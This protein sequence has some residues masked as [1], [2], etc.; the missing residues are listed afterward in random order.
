M[1][2]VPRLNP[3][4]LIALVALATGP[5]VPAQAQAPQ[6]AWLSGAVGLSQPLQSDLGEWFRVEA[7][8]LGDTLSTA[9]WIDHVPLT[10]MPR[11]EVGAPLGPEWSVAL[12]VE[13]YHNRTENQAFEVFSFHEW[14]THIETR[15]VEYALHGAWW[16]EQL[17]GGHVGASIGRAH[18]TV[19]LNGGG[20]LGTDPNQ[21]IF[22]DGTWKD[23]TFTWS[24][25][26]GW[27]SR[28][29][30]NPHVDLRV[31]WQGRNFGQMSARW[32]GWNGPETGPLRDAEG[33]PVGFDFGGPFASLGFAVAFRGAP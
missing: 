7:R 24:V 3:L 12:S 30:E 10:V 19:V 4:T 20:R 14:N 27:Q 11:L 21:Q 18:G 23:A 29:P 5:I 9:G 17:Q 8:R 31:G 28:S 26:G 33:K 2:D 16:P 13:A 32:N 22:L 15:L 6:H 1:H 25:Y